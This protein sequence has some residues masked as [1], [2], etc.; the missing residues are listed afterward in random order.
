[1]APIIEE[2][3]DLLRREVVNGPAASNQRHRFVCPCVPFGGHL[4]DKWVLSLGTDPRKEARGVGVAAEVVAQ[5]HVAKENPRYDER[6]AVRLRVA[7]DK[8]VVQ[9]RSGGGRGDPLLP[10]KKR[11]KM[12][13]IDE[14]EGQVGC[15]HETRRRNHRAEVWRATAPGIRVAIDVVSHSSTTQNSR[16]NDRRGKREVENKTRTKQIDGRKNQR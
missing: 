1:M 16:D 6:A 12:V 13:H 11:T 2:R 15:V 10:G 9:R 5:R 3:L 8:P 14:E 4:N 7:G